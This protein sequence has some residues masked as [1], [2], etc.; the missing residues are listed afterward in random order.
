MARLCT[1]LAERLE[2]SDPVGQ[3]VLN[4]PG[5]PT[6][7]TDALALRLAGALHSLVIGGSD[8][9]LAA[10]YPPN[11][12]G[13]DDLWSAVSHALK[14]HS[15]HVLNMLDSPPQ[16]NE[17]RRSSALMCGLLQVARQFGM[18]IELLELGS[19][20]GLNL[21]A[22]HYRHSLGTHVAGDLTSNVS[23][24]PQWRGAEAVLAPV[25]IVSRAGCDLLPVSLG[26]AA[27]LQ[28]LQAYVWPDQ[29]DR[30]ERLQH[31]WNIASKVRGFAGVDK[32]DAA[33]WLEARLRT[34][35]EGVARVIFH[36]IAWQYFPADVRQRCLSAIE[37][38]GASASLRAPVAHFS[39]EADGG[40]GAAMTLT[41]WPEGNSRMIGRVDFHGRWIELFD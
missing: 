32:A 1:L 4:W 16:T 10:A 26:D 23:L 15:D 39:M 11:N 6:S 12:V 21:F 24:S 18:P 28:R 20:A 37:A 19:S 30:V 5:E 9:V 35:H 17:V 31:A 40:V 36:T 25:E 8:S 27:N 29:T 7:K 3:T 38:A 33:E 22:D 34:P 41:T 13:D 14:L 2:S